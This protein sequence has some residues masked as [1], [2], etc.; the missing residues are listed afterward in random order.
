MTE[1]TESPDRELRHAE[2]LSSDDH[3]SSLDPKAG[4][5]LLG[6]SGDEYEQVAD[7][8]IEDPRG[9]EEDAATP[10]RYSIMSY[11]ADLAV[12]MLLKRLQKQDIIIPAFQRGFVWNLRQASRFVES[13]LLGLPVPEI[14]LFKDPDSRKLLVVDGQQRLLTLMFFYSGLFG[15]K[16]F[17]LRGVCEQFEGKTREELDCSDLRELDQSVI[18]ATIFQQLEPTDDRGSVYSVFER[19]N[20]GGTALQA[21]E[22]RA[23]IYQ[24]PLNDLLRE[25]A[26]DSEWR[27][28]YG[29]PSARKRDEENRPAVLGTIGCT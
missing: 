22:I 25:L 15:R 21:Q 13:L 2:S 6:T 29:P 14:F 7:E 8:E 24:G 16:A 26:N 18:H 28:L 23:S 10:I 20:T 4:N 1:Q 3:P 5:D 9:D 11:G 19:L 12:D 27:S 17:R